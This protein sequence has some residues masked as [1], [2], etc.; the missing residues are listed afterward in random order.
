M[1]NSPAE[2]QSAD[3][4]DSEGEPANPSTSGSRFLAVTGGHEEQLALLRQNVAQDLHDHA[5]QFIAGLYLQLNVINR[6][7]TSD[8]GYKDVERMRVQ[9][10]QLER[11]LHRLGLGSP[12]CS[13]ER[14]LPMAVSVLLN[15]WK[16]KSAFHTESRCNRPE[17][18]LDPVVELNLYR[19]VQEAL[20]N[21][22][23]HA[24]SA[25]NVQVSLQ[26]GETDWELVS[27]SDDGEGFNVGRPSSACISRRPQ[28]GF[29]GMR[30][31]LASIGGELQ[32]SSRL[33]H[34]TAVVAR[35]N[36]IYSELTID[37]AKYHWTSA[38]PPAQGN[39]C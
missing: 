4:C 35:R 13:L 34:G 36:P 5:G 25:T 24:P 10:R 26:F 12:P 32:V 11:E 3:L 20:T 38:L 18:R 37:I 15:D 6:H 28:L 22:A 7:V 16:K 33:K 9:L 27:I 14:G 2:K 8:R 17:L 23:K 21:V 1:L 39:V 29:A 31:R 30:R 19:I